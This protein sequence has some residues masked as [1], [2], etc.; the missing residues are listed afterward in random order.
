M[1][2]TGIARLGA[3]RDFHHGL[4]AQQIEDIAVFERE[5]ASRAGRDLA[6]QPLDVVVDDEEPGVGIRQQAEPKIRR[7]EIGAVVVLDKRLKEHPGSE[8]I[9]HADAGEVGYKIATRQPEVVVAPLES[10]A[11]CLAGTGRNRR[12]DRHAVTAEQPADD[13]VDVGTD[14]RTQV[15]VTGDL[16]FFVVVGARR[17]NDTG[18]Y[19]ERLEHPFAGEVHAGVDLVA[20]PPLGVIVDVR[21][22]RLVSAGLEVKHGVVI[23]VWSELV[24]AHEVLGTERREYTG[25]HPPIALTCE[26]PHLRVEV[27]G[28][29]GVTE[30]EMGPL[31]LVLCAEAVRMRV[32]HQKP[33]RLGC[34]GKPADRA[35]LSDP[36]ASIERI[37]AVVVAIASQAA[38]RLPI[39]EDGADVRAV[40]E[41][42]P[43][44]GNRE[45][46]ARASI[47]A[48]RR[49]LHVQEP[50]VGVAPDLS[51]QPTAA[52]NR[53]L[54]AAVT[55]TDATA[56]EDVDR[57]LLP[58]GKQPGV[59]EK[60]WPLLRKEQ[61]EPV[62]V[63]LL[64]VYL[65]LCEIGVVGQVER[66]ARCHAVLQVG[67]QV[68]CIDVASVFS[69][70]QRFTQDVRRELQVS[71]WRNLDALELPG[72]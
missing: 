38:G 25:V 5:G 17:N 3:T 64:V 48:H 68:A 35:A 20:V 31:G 12:G 43:H 19:L 8:G 16:G 40:G 57:P 49:G 72:E 70:T 24:D 53:N 26:E 37:G 52:D 10:G 28:H 36:P 13:G 56:K 66:H 18:E 41:I 39:D 11:E 63:D 44:A 54:L 4:L 46:L 61:G 14:R 58:D 60:E 51:G 42:L 62:E 33:R 65:H 47:R 45:V 67:T 71:L 29:L 69:P 9:R 27:R 7:P 21:E 50:D 59:L 34:R 15:G 55:E 6:A 1:D 2:S 30:A 22:L 32:A 23:H